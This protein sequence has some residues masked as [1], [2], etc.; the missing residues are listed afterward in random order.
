[1]TVGTVAA[2]V[3]IVSISIGPSTSVTT[4]EFTRLERCEIAREWLKA[5]ALAGSGVVRVECFPK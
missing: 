3:L 4:Q 2:W 1:M 5:N